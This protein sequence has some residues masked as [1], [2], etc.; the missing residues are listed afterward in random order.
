MIILM[1]ITSFV[2]ADK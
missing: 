1:D 2:L